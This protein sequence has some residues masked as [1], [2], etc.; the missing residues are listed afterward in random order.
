MLAVFSS[1]KDQYNNAGI[2]HNIPRNE[3]RLEKIF[4][5]MYSYRT[6]VRGPCVRKLFTG[7]IMYLPSQNKEH[8]I[9]LYRNGIKTQVEP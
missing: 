6:C 3:G 7:L 1:Y 8:C 9:V 4:L 5:S 2:I